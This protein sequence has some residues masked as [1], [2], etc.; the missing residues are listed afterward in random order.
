LWLALLVQWYDGTKQWITLSVLKESNPVDIAEYVTAHGI[1]KEPA[2]AWWIPYTLRKRD[3]I[4]VSV[5]VGTR[6]TTHK[7]GIEFPT[8]VSH[9]HE[10]DRRNGNTLWAAALK[11]EMR[12]VGIA[13][14][15]LDPPRLVPPGWFK[16]SGLIYFL[17]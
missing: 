3:V 10:L 17:M 13:F 9:A 14:E 4:V 11:K 2:F 1:D 15:I 6:K 16:A 7:Y 8:S 12:N 5:S